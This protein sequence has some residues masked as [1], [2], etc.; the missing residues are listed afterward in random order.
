LKEIKMIKCCEIC[1]NPENCDFCHLSGE[2]RNPKT[3]ESLKTYEAVS[4][5]LTKSFV[6]KFGSISAAIDHAQTIAT[7]LIAEN[8][9]GSTSIEWATMYIKTI[10]NL[11]HAGDCNV[12][13]SWLK[14]PITCHACVYDEFML[15]AWNQMGKELNTN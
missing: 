5:I 15:K 14:A 4:K 9:D 2:P 3:G 7:R 11:V 12:C 6:K 10:S 8:E 13:R 1:E